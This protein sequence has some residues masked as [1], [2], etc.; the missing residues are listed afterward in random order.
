MRKPD[1]FIVGGPRSGT[2]AMRTYLGEHPEIFM[3][4]DV[5]PHF[6]G[7][8][9]NSPRFFRHEQDY[10]SLFREADDG[11]RVGEKSPWYLISKRAAAEIK[12]YQASAR[13]MGM[14]H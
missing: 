13:I 2:T 9:L 5:E 10:L 11:K 3:A 4:R 6:F 14:S 1:V 7:T 8:D 12:A